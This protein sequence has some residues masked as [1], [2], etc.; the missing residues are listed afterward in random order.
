M[1][2]AKSWE[3]IEWE[4]NKIKWFHS[5]VAFPYLSVI[6][7][8]KNVKKVGESRFETGVGWHLLNVIW[9]GIRI[10][11]TKP[12]FLFLSFFIYFFLSVSSITN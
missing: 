7:E 3:Y 10:M 12:L 9:N 4:I 11:M 6:D 1:I 5:D 8:S 2:V